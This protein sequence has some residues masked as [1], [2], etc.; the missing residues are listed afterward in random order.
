M[1]CG[2]DMKGEEKPEKEQENEG[3]ESKM[4]EDND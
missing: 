3:K 4:K 2:R 1:A